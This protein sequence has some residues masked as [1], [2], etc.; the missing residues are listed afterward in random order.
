MFKRFGLMIMTNI[1]IMIT[2]GVVWSIVAA[3]LGPKFSVG[4]PYLMVMSLIFGFT[5]SFISLFMSKWMAKTMYGVE[6]IDP[7][8]SSADLRSLVQKVHTLAR[9]AGLEKMP[10]VGIYQSEDV[11]AFATGPSR[12]NS[13]VAVSSGLLRRMTDQ[14]IEGV[15]GHEVSHIA[16]GDM[17]TMTLIQ[18]VVNSFVFF[19]S[20]IVAN[21][22]ASQVE[23]RNRS[24]V[25][26]IAV[27]LCDIAFTF[28]GSMLVSYFSRLR[29]FRADAGSANV[30]GRDKMISALQR[31]QT[32]VDG[33]TNGDGEVDG[34]DALATM[35]ISSSRGTGLAA[36]FM[37]HP[38]LEERIA[39]LQQAQGLR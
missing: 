27:V 11:N 1:L 26:F 6:V 35:K 30:A 37:T 28:L 10:E 22:I 7:N 34:R 23:E 36:L 4:V 21:L 14:E 8:T 38:P 33:P 19:F 17:V 2:V 39:A 24:W 31:L 12:S 16:N 5:G 25:H 9:N 29:E 18:G 20:R 32:L 13:L 3:F 15:L